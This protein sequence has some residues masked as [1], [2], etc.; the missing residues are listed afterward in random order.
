MARKNFSNLCRVS[1]CVCLCVHSLKHA[2]TFMGVKVDGENASPL[3]RMETM[4]IGRRWVHAFQTISNRCLFLYFGPREMEQYCNIML[5]LVLVQY[6]CLNASV[7]LLTS[8]LFHVSHSH[9]KD[10]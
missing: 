6:K 10:G 9:S 2:I 4:G 7:A 5:V 3:M 8:E 1:F